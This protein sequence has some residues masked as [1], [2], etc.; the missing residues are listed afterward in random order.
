[1]SILAVAGL[2]I[3]AC[4]AGLVLLGDLRQRTIPFLLLYGLA[5]LGYA[6]AVYASFR[7]GHGHRT[8]GII[9]GLAVLFRVTL[10]L[11][12]PPTLSDDVYRY[13]W[14]G[15]L[16]NAGVNPFAHAVASPVLDYL[17]SPLRA[18]V[19]H[20]WMATPYLP[21]AQALFALVYRLAPDS[22]LAFQ[23]CAVIFDLLTGWLVM[24]LLRRVGLPEI[25][26]LI[27]LWNPLVLVEFSHGA[28]GDAFTIFLM[29]LALWLL[30]AYRARILSVVALA[31]ATLTKGLPVLLLPVVVWR[32][33]WLR[34]LF[35]AGLIA[36]VCVPFAL[37]AGWGLTGPLDGEGVFGA[38]RIYG[39]FW[40]F[41]G[42]VYPAL[43]TV[44]SVLVGPAAALPK[45]NAAVPFW[46]AKIVTAAM[47]VGV[48]ATVWWIG[49]RPSDDLTLLRRAL[50]PL[51]AYLILTTTVHPWYVTLIVPLLP[52]LSWEKGE[53][54]AARLYLSAALYFTA[55][56]SLSYLNYQAPDTVRE[57]PVVRLLEYVPT[58]VLLIVAAWSTRPTRTDA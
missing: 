41:N 16:T 23:V 28:H 31:A 38:I 13:I 58:Y 15:R 21:V 10:L 5:Y 24:D 49:R 48:L 44:L 25:R 42:S 3:E 46:I 1:L 50:I 36:V 17:D 37:G 55:A 45:A 40:K 8:R 39:A 35:Y 19:N 43:E 20:N 11:T 51:V 18:L 22:P 32:W 47:L 4:L 12:T 2:L 9:W 34:T 6:V 54:K 29:V 53:S 52:F 56:V 7:A 57:Y 26:S 27:Y 14:D 33:G 30:I